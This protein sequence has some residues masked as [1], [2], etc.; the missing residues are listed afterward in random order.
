MP[1]FAD[2][3]QIVSDMNMTSGMATAI[4]EKKSI[5]PLMDAQLLENLTEDL[6]VFI[7]RK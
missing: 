3:E 1:M 6:Y 5:E 7:F 4:F 2:D